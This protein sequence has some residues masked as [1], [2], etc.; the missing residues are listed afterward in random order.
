VRV[1]TLVKKNEFEVSSSWNSGT[2]EFQFGT[3]R[4]KRDNRIYEV[5]VIDSIGLFDTKQVPN[6]EIIKQA[7]K[8]LQTNFKDGIHL[9]LFTLPKGTKLTKEENEAIDMWIANAKGLD[10]N[11]SQ[12]SALIFTKFMG[13]ETSRANYISQFR[14]SSDTLWISQFMCKGI[15]AVDFPDYDDVVDE[16]KLAFQ[17]IDAKDT[18]T[19]HNFVFKDVHNTP[20]L[21]K[22]ISEWHCPCCTI[23]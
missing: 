3:Y 1:T 6:S 12:I 2:V 7:K 4:H 18:S 14:S 21:A 22:E 10:K 20:I 11:V 15:L 8:S 13:S 19:L 9:I 17:V 5:N 23:L 16:M